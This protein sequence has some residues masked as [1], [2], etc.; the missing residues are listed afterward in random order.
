MLLPWSCLSATD[1]HFCS[2][3]SQPPKMPAS[4][5]SEQCSRLDLPLEATHHGSKGA[6]DPVESAE[7]EVGSPG[8]RRTCDS[9]REQELEDAS[10]AL[11]E[12]QLLEEQRRWKAEAEAN[13]QQ[14]KELEQRVAVSEQMEQARA[15]TERQSR[16]AA[17]TEAEGLQR[18]REELE[19][20][21]ARTQLA[22]RELERQSEFAKQAAHDR[23]L[24][25]LE[26]ESE[27]LRMSSA[28]REEQSRLDQQRRHV[29][30]LQ[31]TLTEHANPDDLCVQM[32]MDDSGCVEE[33][34]V[35][36]DGPCGGAGD[37]QVTLAEA[38]T[39][40]EILVALPSEESNEVWDLDW[41]A[42]AHRP[43]EPDAHSGRGHSGRHVSQH[44]WHGLRHI[45]GGTSSGGF[46]GPIF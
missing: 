26:E 45:A 3:L 34:E 36:T 13:A 22:A 29:L 43:P 6:E 30:L 21:Q 46:Q 16:E 1:E 42:L 35:Q 15:K 8:R 11:W 23:E 12:V 14:I 4:A 37:S 17:L 41:N 19:Q 44:R 28:L 31:R 40:G 9:V 39:S 33:E 27:Q 7:T 10:A 38:D 2:G 5:D 18:Q 20:L 32:Q 24:R 25:M